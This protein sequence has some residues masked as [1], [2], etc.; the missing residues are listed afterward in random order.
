MKV[1]LTRKTVYGNTLNYPVN[2]T[3]KIF[4]RMVNRLTLNYSDLVN[5]KNLGYEIIYE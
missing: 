5:I 4:A 1:I 3:A 2:E